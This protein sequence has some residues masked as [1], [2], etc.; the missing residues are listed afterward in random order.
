M[1]ADDSIWLTRLLSL[2][3]FHNNNDRVWMEGYFYL[4]AGGQDVNTVLHHYISF[5]PPQQVQQQQH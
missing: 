4:Q 5:S 2:L 3:P 1:F